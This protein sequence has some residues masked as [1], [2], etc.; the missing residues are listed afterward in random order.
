MTLDTILFQTESWL[1]K[2]SPYVRDSRTFSIPSLAKCCPFDLWKPSVT[3][4]CVILTGSALSFL[5]APL[6]TA[7]TKQD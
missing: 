2:E 7:V 1:L 5:L 3:F 6:L 4:I